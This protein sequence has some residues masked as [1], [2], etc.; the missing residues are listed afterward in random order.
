MIAGALN[1]RRAGGA[2]EFICGNKLRLRNIRLLVTLVAG[3]GKRWDR[4]VGIW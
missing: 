2:P 1:G 3:L 4:S